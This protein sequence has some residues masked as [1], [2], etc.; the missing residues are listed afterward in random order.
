MGGGFYSSTAR[1][2]SA[3]ST[4]YATQSVNAIFSQRDTHKEMSTV[5]LDIRE[6]R[7]SDEHPNSYP[8]IIGLDVTGSMGHI[9]HNLIKD[10]L[11]TLMQNVLDHGVPDPQIMFTAIGDH[12]CDRSPLQA[13]QFESSD[14]LMDHWLERVYLE[15]GGGGNAGESYHLAWHFAAN[16]TSTDSWE[17]R[18]HKGCLITI[19]DE[20][21]LRTLPGH[22]IDSI[23]GKGQNQDTTAAELLSKAQETYYVYH[24]HVDHSHRRLDSGWSQ[25][26]GDNAI[27]VQSYKDIPEAISTIVATHAKENTSYA[28]QGD[29]TNLPDATVN[30]VTDKPETLEEML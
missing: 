14:E 2:S 21:C 28:D 8:V 3:R 26:L 20:P 19:G 18:Q 5:G 11:P 16:H 30:E 1:A 22:S 27:V 24:I 13:G 17:K 23:M 4:E 9:P 12:E 7:D 10:G 15:G 29:S 25:L 6:S